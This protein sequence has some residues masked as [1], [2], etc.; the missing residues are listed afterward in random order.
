MMANVIIPLCLLS[1]FPHQEPRFLLPLLLPIVFTTTKYFTSPN[2]KDQHI[3]PI[4]CFS[5]IVGLIFYGY[6]HQAGVTPMI[7][8]IFRDI[9]YVSNIHIVHSHTYSI[10]VGLL[11]VRQ[12]RESVPLTNQ[13][14]VKVY[15]LGSSLDPDVIYETLINISKN[16]THEENSVIYFAL[17]GPLIKQFELCGNMSSL[18]YTKQTF[19][20]HLSMESMSYYLASIL[21]LMYN[22][23]NKPY[24]G[25]TEL[26]DIFSLVLY[27]I[28]TKTE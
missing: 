27:T 13:R 14:Q 9:K 6:L 4:W 3:F 15:S 17:S 26:R 21:D 5:N 10:P 18:T 12:P 25:L 24:F 8:H 1:I 16:V 7:S 20:P 11:M 19:F 2:T 23:K 22:A 28:K